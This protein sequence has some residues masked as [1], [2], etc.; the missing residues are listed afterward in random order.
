[1]PLS[2][3][4]V[5]TKDEVLENIKSGELF[6]FARVSLYVLEERFEKFKEFCPIFKTRLV[7]KD[8]LSPYA[9]KITEENGLLK[10]GRKTLISVMKA[11]RIVLITPLI[12]W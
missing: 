10:H 8:D 11:D 7:T 3:H 4:S 6:G 12:Q 9:L 1:M 5:L 2:H